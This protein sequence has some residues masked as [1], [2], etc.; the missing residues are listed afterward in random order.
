MIP[1]TDRERD[2]AYTAL[3]RLSH[4][5]IDR[6]LSVPSYF[7]QHLEDLFTVRVLAQVLAANGAKPIWPIGEVLNQE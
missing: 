3:L 5:V 1:M 2:V 4:E 6:G 7:D